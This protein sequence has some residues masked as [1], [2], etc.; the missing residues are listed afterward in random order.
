MLSQI[1]RAAAPLALLLLSTAASGQTADHSTHNNGPSPGEPPATA[2]FRAANAAMHRDMD[3]SF[4]GNADA[5]FLRGMIPHHQ[6]AVDMAR[7]VLEYGSDPEVRKLA[8]AVITAQEAEIEWMRGWL[9]A[10]GY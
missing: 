1:R 6:G 5:D 7:A 10:H 8:E 3:I 2:A 4:T 9:A